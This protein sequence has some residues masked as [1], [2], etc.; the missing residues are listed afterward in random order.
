MASP[1]EVAHEYNLTLV[2]QISNDYDA[3][4]VAVNHQEYQDYDAAFFKSIM[5]DN[6]IL[7][8]IKS[9]YPKPVENGLMYWRL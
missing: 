8:D 3:V 4:I 7:M 6:P 5:T 2:D 9:I 1:N